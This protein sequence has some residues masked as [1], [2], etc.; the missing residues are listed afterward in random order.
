VSAERNRA[1]VPRQMCQASPLCLALEGWQVIGFS[2]G[3]VGFL[4]AAIAIV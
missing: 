3:V 4:P 1:D 2:L